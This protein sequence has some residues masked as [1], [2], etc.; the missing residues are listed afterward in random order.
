MSTLMGIKLGH[1]YRGMMVNVVADN[2]KLVE[3]AAGIV[4]NIAGVSRDDAKAAIST[5]NASIKAAILIAKGCTAS[6][7]IDALA[8]HDGHLAACFKS[9]NLNQ[10]EIV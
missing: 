3:R 4:S 9:L 6:Q 1:V 5:A 2:A 8:A 7:A 10:D